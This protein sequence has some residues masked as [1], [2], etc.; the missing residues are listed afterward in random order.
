[1]VGV[2]GEL[3]AHALSEGARLLSS[4]QMSPFLNKN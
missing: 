4:S 2:K 1:M 3:G